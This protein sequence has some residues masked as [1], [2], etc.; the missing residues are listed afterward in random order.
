M[1]SD[2]NKTSLG[3]LRTANIANLQTGPFGTVLKASEYTKNGVPVISVGEIREGFLSVTQHTPRVDQKI[4]DRLSKYVLKTGDI[5]FGRKGAIDRNAIICEEQNG[6]FLGSDGIRLRLSEEVNSSF[7]SYQLR[8]SAI[9]KWLLQNSTGSVMPSLNQKILDRLPLWLPNQSA[10]KNIGSIL[11]TLDA[12]IDLNNRINVELESLARTIYDY[13]FLQFDF[14]DAEGRPYR[15][16]GGRMRYDEAL[17]R[18]VPEGWSVKPLKSIGKISGGSTP[19][20]AN[21]SFFTTEG[22]PWITPKDLSLN[23]GKIF[24]HKGETDVTGDGLKDANL[25]VLPKGSVLMTS[26]APVGY[27]AIASNEV[28]TNQGFKSFV[29]NA[30]YSTEF[31]YFLLSRYMPL[32]EKN[33]S[34]STFK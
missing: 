21:T 4:V 25:K 12:K 8:T 22:T 31:V 14:P 9:G 20:R 2:W 18:E 34:G 6:W 24:V 23:K 3:K 33:A 29:P 32:I 17:G 16:A 26:R 30:Y 27:L 11:S 28:T 5:V 7:V 10:Q 15:S 13:W 1:N 19:S